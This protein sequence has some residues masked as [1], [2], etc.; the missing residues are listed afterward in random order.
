MRFSELKYARVDVPALI[1][2][3]DRLTA[4]LASAETAEQAIA[5]IRALNEHT[6]KPATMITIASIRSS[7]NTKDAFYEGEQQYYAEAMPALTDRMSAFHMQM[8][9]SPFRAEIERVF[10]HTATLNAE[11]EAKTM[12]PEVLPLLGEE[13]LLCIEYQK[14][15][16]AMTVEFEGKKYS[17]PQMKPFMDSPDRAV[18]RAAY[19]AVGQAYSDAQEGFERVYDKLVHKRTEIARKLGFETYT[20]LG[21]LRMTRNSYNPEMV[22]NFREQ[23]KSELV[24][25]VSELKKA[26]AARIG[27]DTLK[28]YDDGVMVPGGNPKPIAQEEELYQ[29]GLSVYR[30]MKP[31]TKEM[32]DKMDE[33][34]TFDLFSREGKMTGGYCSALKEYG[35]PYIF[36]NFN[37]TADDVEVFTHEGGHAFADYLGLKIVPD[38]LDIAMPTLETCECHSMSMEFLCWPSLGR[39]YGADAERAKVIHLIHA[40]YFIPYGCMVDE[41]QHIVYANPDFTPAQRNQAWQKLEQQYRPWA[42]FDNMPFYSDGRLWQRQLH[43]FTDPFYYIDY[44]LAQTI[45]LQFMELMTTRGWDAAW[46]TYLALIRNTGK[47]TFTETIAAAGLRSPFEDGALSGALSAVKRYLD[48]HSDVL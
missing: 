4:Q 3:T 28:F 16:G 14:L 41:F 44:C 35:V 25:L 47:V 45:A 18:R 39:F 2:E 10:G 40:L 31:E 21:Y 37:G 23:V 19:L 11:I 46:E 9:K 30:H 7:Q 32:I 29:I 48:A 42:D 34:G 38:L 36:A 8:V 33:M 15:Q 20:P 12:S 6:K 24:P 5:C 27:V 26:Q 17:V 13:S 43:I 1:D 22:A